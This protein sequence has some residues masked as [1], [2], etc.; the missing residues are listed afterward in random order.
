[1]SV[2]YGQRQKKNSPIA[3]SKCNTYYTSE[4]T[5]YIPRMT[6]KWYILYLIYS[7]KLSTRCLSGQ[8]VG[9]RATK[10]YIHYSFWLSN[11]ESWVKIPPPTTFFSFQFFPLSLS[12]CSFN[13]PSNI[14]ISLPLVPTHPVLNNNCE[15]WA[16][17][18][19]VMNPKTTLW[20]YQVSNKLSPQLYHVRGGG[21]GR[22]CQTSL[23]HCKVLLRSLFCWEVL[24]GNLV[25]GIW[26]IKTWKSS[27]LPF[28]PC[29]NLDWPGLPG[30]LV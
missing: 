17:I 26:S 10:Q 18:Q 19:R 29:M 12:H 5:H 13:F 23:A 20:V 27:L 22:E 1:M 15:I 11:Q 14:W 7:L 2:I 8:K 24:V 4:M 30:F 3:N 28:P 21:G 16:V 9:Q 25:S 6:N